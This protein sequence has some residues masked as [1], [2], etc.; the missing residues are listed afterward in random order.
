MKNP[1]VPRPAPETVRRSILALLERGPRTAREIS[2][3]VH[4]P[5]REVGAHL[6]HLGKSLR[7]IG[8]RLELEPAVCLS[9][10]FVFRKR[11][12]PTG[13]G[14]CPICKGEF[15]SEPSFRVEIRG[16]AVYNIGVDS[17]S[18]RGRRK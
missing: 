16:G 5:E 11:E 15:I 6:V 13:P 17:A 14:R 1:P 3:A 2:A 9:C 4:I 8:K 7:A 18:C 12:R 10:G